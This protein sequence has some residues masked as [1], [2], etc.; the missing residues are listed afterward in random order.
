[1]KVALL[2]SRIRVEE[3]LLIDEL[4]QRGVDHEIID[5]R[6]HVFDI[7]D[8]TPWQ[9][10][11][12]AIERCISQTQAVTITAIFETCG[13]PVIN[14]RRVIETCG[15][16]LLT[17]LLLAHRGVP[18]P[19]VRIAL[20]PESAL[21]AV[22]TIGYPAVLKPTIGSWGRLIARL[23]DRD[24]AEAVIEHKSTLGG[25]QHGVFYVQ[26]HIEKPG[27]DIRVFM[28]GE[29]PLAAITRRSPH[30][31]TNT[32]RGGK[33]ANLAIS[34]ELAQICGRAVSAIAE[35]ATGE[36]CDGGLFV[37]APVLAID[38]LECPRRGLLVGEINHTME[39][40][41]S[42]ATTGV[43]IPARIIDH[44]IS[45]AEAHNRWRSRTSA[46]PSA[47]AVEA[48]SAH[49]EVMTT[50]IEP[51]SMRPFSRPSPIASLS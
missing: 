50:G 11:D 40:R 9:R 36:G 45:T 49:S 12:V 6:S 4:Q 48:N 21:E 19:A 23:N 7:H 14:P 27:R 22:E 46:A 35:S 3:R 31:I 47:V 24:A 32:A 38:L 37:P 18:T 8:F 2:T 44:A 15:D 26:E 43:D 13:I 28:I 33:A 16:K 51:R 30:W 10:F 20:E 17:S 1:M 42:I 34:Q 29:R 25:F 5:V 39:F 41:N